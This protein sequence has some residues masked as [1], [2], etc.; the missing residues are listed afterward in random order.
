M[1]IITG[2]YRF[3]ICDPTNSRNETGLKHLS[4]EGAS[5]EDPN[6]NWEDEERTNG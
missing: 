1:I 5:E 6:R 4:A 2:K 3:P